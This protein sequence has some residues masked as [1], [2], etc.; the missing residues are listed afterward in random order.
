MRMDATRTLKIYTDGGARGNPG[1]A[2]YGFLVYAGDEKLYEEGKYIGK[3]TNNVAEYS[4][5]IAGMAKAKELGA[6]GVEVFS[7]SELVIKQMRGEY[8]VKKPHLQDLHYK[9]LKLEREFDR[10][11]YQHRRRSERMQAAADALV[12]AALDAHAKK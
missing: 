9:V 2:A 10:V 1:P 5:I 11:S 8:K 3:V 12:N 6:S 4:A 7:D